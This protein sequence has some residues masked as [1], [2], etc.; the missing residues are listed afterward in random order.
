MPAFGELF[1]EQTL[2][3]NYLLLA[4][5]DTYPPLA[6]LIKQTLAA[7]QQAKPEGAC[8]SEQARQGM[9]FWLERVPGH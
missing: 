9:A 6:R 5:A 2:V 4:P 7:D 3:E 8:L 1:A